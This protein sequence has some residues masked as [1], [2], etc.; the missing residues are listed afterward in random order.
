MSTGF[1]VSR[2]SIRGVLVAA[3]LAAGTCVQAE[4]QAA[5]L[6]Q[7][8]GWLG[9]EREARPALAEQGFA[10]MPLT[11]EEASTA[12]ARLW[13]DRAEV[14]AK[15]AAAAWDARVI[16][17]GDV[18]M[19]FE[20]REFGNK[21]EGERSLFISLHGGGGAP[22]VVNDGQWR[23]QIDLYKPE[24]GIYV[25]P[26]SPTNDW[27]LW[28]KDHIDPLFDRLIEI[29]V[30]HKGVNPNRV[31]LL[32]YSAGGDGLYQVAPR[33]ADR[34][35]AAA[36]MAGH[37]NNAQPM[38]LRNTPFAIYMGGRDTA[39]RRNEVAA[40]WRDWLGRLK[41]AD[42]E[43]YPHRVVIYP[44]H[45]HWMNLDDAEALPWMARH[46]RTP[47]PERIVWRQDN[48][49]H[50][51]FYWLAAPEDQRVE[52]ALI[53][54]EREGQ[55]IRILETDNLKRITF[56]LNDTMMDLDQPVRVLAADG[57]VLFEGKVTRS[58]R[59]LAESMA[60]RM[61]RHHLFTAALPVEL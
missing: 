24:E 12:A 50:S 44:Q 15:E 14:L 2:G 25:A 35:A 13:R 54:V 18:R 31:Y 55:T 20:F 19:R 40:E 30:E 59:H 53:R 43:G 16:T 42:P 22:A 51:R 34:W 37:P 28:H 36:M 5:P 56:L 48:V 61:D 1:K 23:N 32:G 11:R 27:D 17:H 7:L 52:G 33:M 39:Y 9:L 46:T 38:N 21:P 60:H 26:R 3:V 8:E 29:A 49:T 6:A 45:G 57:R 4:E 41:E 10:A 58:I 47:L